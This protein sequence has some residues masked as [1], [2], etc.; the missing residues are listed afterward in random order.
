MTPVVPSPLADLTPQSATV[1]AGDVTM[2]QEVPPAVG[3]TSEHSGD[4]GDEVWDRPTGSEWM[5]CAVTQ[6][7]TVQTQVALEVAT[8]C[9][10]CDKLGDAEFP[11]RRP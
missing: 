7:S 5:E 3:S 9:D 2:P 8:A 10:E 11:E 1:H 6:L 4:D